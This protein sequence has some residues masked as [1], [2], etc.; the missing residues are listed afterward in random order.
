MSSNASNPNEI[1]TD[2]NY[3]MWEFN[4]RMALARKGLQDHI[5]AMKPEDAVRRNTDK[6]KSADMKALVVVAKMLS[7]TYQLMVKEPTS[8][9]DAWEILRQSP[10]NRVQLRKQLHEFTLSSGKDLM[11]HIFDLMT[12]VLA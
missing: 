4:A 3:F 7:P 6:W 5:A 2:T 8:A 12:C 10:H 11:H 1:P 9:L